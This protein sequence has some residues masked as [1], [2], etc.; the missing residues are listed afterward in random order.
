MLRF[1]DLIDVVY[2]NNPNA[3]LEMLEEV[4]RFAEDLHKDQKRKSGEPYI[5]HPLS[6]ALILA[7]L[8]LD[9]RAIAAGLLHDIAEDTNCKV[10][11]LIDH[12]GEEISF[13]V[14]G[15]TKLSKLE[16]NSKEERQ[17]ESYR[18]MFIAMAE[19]IRVIIIKLAD[20]LHNMRTMRFQAPQK[21]KE[22]ARETLEI[23]SPIANRLGISRLQWELEDLCL[24]YMEPDIYYDLVS[25]ISMK[26]K[27][28]EEYINEVIGIL[29][30]EL[31]KADIEMEI[32]GR[33]KHFYSIYKKMVKQH[34]DLN[35]LYD[36]IAVR[37]LVK[38]IKDCYAALGVV[39]TLWKPIPGR[40]KD[41][42]AMPKANMYQSLHTTVIGPKGERFEI[43]IRTYEMHMTAEY[44]IAAHWLYKETGGS[45]VSKESHQLDWLKQLKEMQLETSDNKEFVESVKIDLF[46]D[47]VFVFSPMGDVYE[48]PQGATPIDFA[49]KVHTNVGN[50]CIGAKVNK[51]IVPL[52]YTLQNGEIVEILTSKQMNGP[53]Q[54]W[55]SMAKTSMAKNKI[56]Q[57][58]RK[59]RR[60]ETINKG[61]DNLEREI[62]K[63][64]LESAIYAKA[65]NITLIAPKLSYHNKEEIYMAIGTQALSAAQVISKIK[66][67]LHLDKQAQ[68]ENL[69]DLLNSKSNREARAKNKKQSKNT[70]GV[71]VNGIDNV[72]IK[73]AHCCKPVPGDEIVGYI[74]RGHGVTI[75]RKD[76]GNLRSLPVEEQ[77]RITAA[78]WEDNEDNV[79]QVELHIFAL[80]RP[81]IT[82][83][84]MELVND[85][86]V[87]ISAI[88]GVSKGINSIIDMSIDVANV[89]QMNLMIDKIR[90][91]KD[92]LEVK[93][94]VS[95]DKKR[96]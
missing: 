41:Y 15:V 85:S 9:E 66:E 43:Q 23:Y 79:F 87:H 31:G 19:D 37:I 53:G 25:Q 64:G 30:D 49:Y 54:N 84:I 96:R 18:K 73:F 93:R 57:W 70:S 11:G 95:G 1:K 10:S 77:G 75:H 52:D 16:C 3:D 22:I 2:E 76:C 13:L 38:D 78:Q 33:P 61:K 46:S 60:E 47:T 4:Y 35:E 12:F 44:G 48:L 27:E 74:T 80:D 7:E 40:F 65:D 69:E 86:K 24:R 91:I 36:L 67:E 39:H 17:L 83:D 42:I 50:R 29:T 56:K 26:R 68:P 55:L 34:K 20:R 89:E 62:K 92:V 21:Q 94:N 14:N 81:K 8:G 45:N 90:S 6:V 72:S 28:R 58:Y 88:S 32:A 82:A 5:M 63:M 59:D 71:V 51:R